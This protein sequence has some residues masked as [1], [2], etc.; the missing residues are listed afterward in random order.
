MICLTFANAGDKMTVN[1][2]KGEQNKMICKNCNHECPDDSTFCGNCGTRLDDKTVCSCGTTY[3]GNFCPTCGKKNP[4][5]RKPSAGT[6]KLTLDRVLNIASVF[7][8][9]LGALCALVFTFFIGVSQN[10]PTSGAST[11]VTSIDLYYYFSE[12]YVGLEGLPSNSPVTFAR[13]FNAI[14][15]TVISALSL[16]V[17]SVIVLV[18]I[19]KII[20]AVLQKKPLGIKLFSSIIISYLCS[21]VAFLAF[22]AA[23]SRRTVNN[24]LVSTSANTFSVGANDATRVGMT[25]CIIL[26]ALA[27]LTKFVARRKE[28]LKPAF[29]IDTCCSVVKVVLS[30][31]VLSLLIM[32]VTTA[33]VSETSTTN[34]SIKTNGSFMALVNMLIRALAPSTSA[35]S[36]S[37]GTTITEFN[38]MIAPVSDGAIAATVFSAI[39]V[40]FIALALCRY[41]SAFDGSAKMR[42][43]TVTVEVFA[44]LIGICYFVFSLVSVSAI[45][46]E[47]TEYTTV[48]TGKS[49]A[50]LVLVILTVIVTVIQNMISR[51]LRSNENK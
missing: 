28:F 23:S 51:E 21:A 2:V 50:V 22:N 35:P 1:L 46:A 5:A 26:L 13:Y 7:L 32:P 43:I 36:W 29:I 19:G 47:F 30:A 16:A 48:T 33:S 27:L 39:L 18:T 20:L 34:A 9:A 44:M 4:S 24:S 25:M 45:P 31:V 12:A 49:T 37:N 15:G 8:T 40:V 17:T 14:F 3:E 42:A 41:I 11:D 38:N 10:L 6:V